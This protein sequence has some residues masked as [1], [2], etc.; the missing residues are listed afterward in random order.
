MK[1]AK[2]RRDRKIFRKT[3]NKTNAKNVFGFGETRGMP[4]L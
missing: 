1:Y 4:K 3:A 2:S